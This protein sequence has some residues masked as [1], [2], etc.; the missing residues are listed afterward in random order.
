[1]ADVELI[2]DIKFPVKSDVNI[3]LIPRFNA[4]DL[5]PL[6]DKERANKIHTSGEKYFHRD[7]VGGKSRWFIYADDSKEKPHGV[8]CSVQEIDSNAPK[9][10][11]QAM[12]MQMDNKL[13]QHKEHYL[14]KKK[15]ED[16]MPPKIEEVER[17]LNMNLLVYGCS[18]KSTG[19]KLK[20]KNQDACID[21]SSGRTIFYLTVGQM[22]YWR[23]SIKQPSASDQVKMRFSFEESIVIVSFQH[24]F[25]GGAD[26]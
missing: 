11:L 25:A 18:G 26:S 23:I 2:P 8:I 10:Y 5:E 6:T 4:V 3:R 17:A 21:R 20:H 19:I 1:M 7:N 13:H 9:L 14:R 16:G 12:L 22:K 15:Q 24:V